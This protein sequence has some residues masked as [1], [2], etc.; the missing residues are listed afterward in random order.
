MDKNAGYCKWRMRR[1]SRSIGGLRAAILPVFPN[2]E[3]ISRTDDQGDITSPV[4]HLVAGED[5]A[6]IVDPEQQR[7]CLE[8]AADHQ[9]ACR[10]I[11]NG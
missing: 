2:A 8:G 1:L 4:L 5:V 7:A 9:S 11:L 6:P 3:P 10:S